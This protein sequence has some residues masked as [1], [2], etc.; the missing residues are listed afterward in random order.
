MTLFN[1]LHMS[2]IHFSENYRADLKKVGDALL[3]DLKKFID[4]ETVLKP[5]AVIFTG[6]L[7]YDGKA[8]DFQ[9]AWDDFINPVLNIFRLNQN[10]FFICP[11]NHDIE[12]NRIDSIVDDGLKA[13]LVNN[14]KVNDFL[15]SLDKRP[16]IGFFSRLTN[17][18]EFKASKESQHKI[19]GNKLFSTYIIKKQDWNIGIALLNTA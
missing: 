8:T 19:R 7:T 10:S 16:D 17:F 6:D 9:G 13:Q 4:T 14:N 5:D 2:D 3:A 1:L 18:E 12:R 11:G 15:D